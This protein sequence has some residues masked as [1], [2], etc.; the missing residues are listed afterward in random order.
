MYT[1]LLNLVDY[2]GATFP[3]PWSVEPTDGKVKRDYLSGDDKMVDD[4]CEL[5]LLGD[6]L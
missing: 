3:T 2:P 1:A 6:L 5:K 4:F